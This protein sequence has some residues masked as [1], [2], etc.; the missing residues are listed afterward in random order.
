MNNSSE[1]AG[2]KA[3]FNTIMLYVL[4]V[5]KIVF[6][7]L[8]LPFLTRTLSVDCYGA[9][10]YVKSV[11]AYVQIIIDFGFILSSVKDIVKAQEDKDQ[12]NYIVG[13][14]I[15]AKFLL[16]LVALVFI[17]ILALTV[18]ILRSYRLLLFLSFL[19]PLLSIFLL[20]FFF[21]GIEKM[22]IV[23]IIFVTMKTI[24]TVLTVTL[25]HNDDQ[26]LL[27]PIFDIISSFT[28]ILLSWIIFIKLGYR[29]K[30]NGIK[31][32]VVKIKDSCLYFTNSVASSAF[33]ALNTAII[34]ICIEDLQQV[35]F[36]SVSMQLVGAIQTMYTPLSN[37]IYPYMIKNKNLTVIKKILLVFMPLVIGGTILAGW[38]SPI[39]LTIVSGEKYRGASVV[40]KHLLPI[41][42]F[43]FPV[44][45]LGWPTLGSIDKI[46][47]INTS[48]FIGAFVQITGLLI[49]YIFDSF[50]ILN[51][52]ILRNLS[53][54]SM[55]ITLFYFTIKYRRLFASESDK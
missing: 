27:I 6:P 26:V 17:L 31:N 24:S 28:A 55:C 42:I 36:W 19:P 46:K 34:G 5:A 37:G 49:L 44:T 15:F 33:G 3:L 39:L 32:A 1:N 11:I 41:L 45:V 18:P 43:S 23:S 54:I 9:V 51:V 4:A 20:D 2:K 30:A 13:N 21:R 12:V 14:T 8:T 40:F 25:I 50:Y 22:H 47:A 52:A 53:E 7:L 35:A 48:T 16:S 29:I 38:L 10:S